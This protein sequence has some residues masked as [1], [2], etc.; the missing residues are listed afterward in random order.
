MD[1]SALTEGGFVGS[2]SYEGKKVDLGFDDAGAGVF[3]TPE[4]SERL[5]VKKGSRVI[6]TVDSDSIRVIEL[7]VAGLGTSTRISDPKAYYAVGRE[8]G[9][10]LRLRRA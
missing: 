10:I 2:S 8:G 4:M 5:Q 9:A 3:L 7:V 1:V 6:L